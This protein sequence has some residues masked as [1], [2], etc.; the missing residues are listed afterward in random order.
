MSYSNR[1]LYH[2]GIPGQS[3]GKRRGPPYPL[4]RG[5][6]GRIVGSEKKTSTEKKEEPVKPEKKLTKKSTKSYSDQELR[7]MVAR[8]GLEKQY[9]QLKKELYPEQQMY[10]QKFVKSYTSNLMNELPKTASRITLKF[11]ES[12]VNKSLGL[13]DSGDGKKKN[14]DKS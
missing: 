1:E 14:K 8:M 10:L 9:N 13:Q 5:K 6:S 2:H 4:S 7:D 12:Q 3:W 11:I